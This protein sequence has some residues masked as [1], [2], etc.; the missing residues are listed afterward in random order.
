MAEET[1]DVLVLIGRPASG[2]SKIIDYLAHLPDSTRRERFHMARADYNSYST[3][4][5]FTSLDNDDF[6][7]QD[8]ENEKG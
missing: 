8:D 5:G 3:L 2:K 7:F 6:L 4:T 1:F